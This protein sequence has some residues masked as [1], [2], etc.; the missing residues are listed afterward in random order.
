MQ[1]ES[2][3]SM[4]V[5]PLLIFVGLIYY[6]LRLLILQDVDA[7]RG[8]NQNK[9]VKNEEMYAKTAGKLLLFLAIASLC[10]AL[11]FC[12]SAIAA[13]VEICICI[14]IFGILWRKMDIKYGG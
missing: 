10:M 9:K 1:N 4:A 11:L 14:V 7:I 8:R 12:V 2:F 6:A 5:I 3:L 13:V